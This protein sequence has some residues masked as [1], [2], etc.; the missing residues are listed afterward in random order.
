[1]KTYAFATALLLGSAVAWPQG[2]VGDTVDDIHAL[3]N[4]PSARLA[5][6]ADAPIK[7]NDLSP[8]KIKEVLDKASKN[9][10]KRQEDLSFED[11][12]E[13]IEGL[14]QQDATKRQEDLSPEEIEET[15]GMILK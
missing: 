15:I 12:K 7:N 1:M 11:L 14:G 4:G 10:V 9:A 6:E 13:I 8:E 2:A 5:R 3:V